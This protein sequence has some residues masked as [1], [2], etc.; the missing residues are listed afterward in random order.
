MS[1]DG[2]SHIS[3]ISP[4]EDRKAIRAGVSSGIANVATTSAVEDVTQLSRASQLQ[5]QVANLKTILDGLNQIAAQTET[6]KAGVDQIEPLLQNISSIIQQSQTSEDSD[7]V[8]LQQD[9]QQNL[10]AINQIVDTASF[11]G[12]RIL[13]GA[14]SG[15]KSISLSDI[16]HP[17]DSEAKGTLSVPDLSTSG[18]LNGQT[19]DI[20]ADSEEGNALPVVQDALS[21][22]QTL[23]ND[24]ATFQGSLD[25]ATASVVTAITNHDAA[26]AT[27]STEDIE[28]TSASLSQLLQHSSDVFSAQG[29][30]A[31]ISIFQLIG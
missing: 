29:S 22:L 14:L 4:R 15:D 28:N 20:S 24:I 2:I 3:S 17:A 23:H 7:S 18:L 31:G 1:I 26:H 30:G 16:L 10:D 25:F 19:I 5:Y 13:N 21:T 11:G 12:N 6:V 9:V 27:L 8:A